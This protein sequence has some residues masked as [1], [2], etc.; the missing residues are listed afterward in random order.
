MMSS[1]VSNTD[2]VAPA[3]EVQSL[4]YALLGFQTT[5]AFEVVNLL[6]VRPGAGNA[7]P[8][9]GDGADGTERGVSGCIAWVA[10]GDSP[11]A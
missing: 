10:R 11:S 5:N 4:L 2:A 6:K 3:H 7:L 9:S 1:Q 8:R